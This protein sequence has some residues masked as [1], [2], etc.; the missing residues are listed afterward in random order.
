MKKK[1]YI[2]I[3]NY[4]GWKDTIECLESV[5]KLD[6]SNFQILVIDNSP[7]LDS[8]KA[9]EK[10]AKGIN[11]FDIPTSFPNIVFPLVSKPI[12]HKIISETE[13]KVK[14]YDHQLLIIKADKNLGFSAGNNI[15]LKYAIRRDDFE[16]CW[17]LNNDTIVDSKSLSTQI[18]YM[19]ANN[20]SNI[21]ILGSKLIY[22]FSPEKIQAVGGAFNTKLYV[23]KHIGEGRSVATKKEIFQNIDYVIG[24][25]MFVS[26][27]FL[28]EVGIL[29]EAYFLYF[30]ELDWAYRSREKGWK[31][32]WCPQS[33]V[34][35]KEGGS[36]G[37]SSNHKE[38]S[39]FSE[40]NVFHSRKTFVRIFFNLGIMYI[41]SSLLIILNR[42]RRF[43]F[44]LALE[45]FKILVSKR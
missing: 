13:S 41:I 26:K 15:G 29:N 39:F 7:G 42:A 14:F 31:M 34:Y 2:I 33:R 6:I 5:L 22:Y 44:K 1:V 12:D 37:S 35:H 10:W 25:S 36:I 18:R 24:A 20:R 38:R 43:Q 16:Y 28:A 17:L 9:I 23:T 3:L 4:N 8:I 45:L 19:D 32:D 21:G 40:I 27:A 11:F 30:E